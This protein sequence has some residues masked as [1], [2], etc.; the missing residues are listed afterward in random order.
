MSADEGSLLL[1]WMVV[2]RVRCWAVARGLVDLGTIF[3]L[4]P[5]LVALEVVVDI[6]SFPKLTMLVS[7]HMASGI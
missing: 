3:L 1:G 7:A 2:S 6:D 4:L 5:L